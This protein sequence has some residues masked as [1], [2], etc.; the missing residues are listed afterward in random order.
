MIAWQE[1]LNTDAAHYG[2]GDVTNPDPVMPEDGR[3][4][5]TLPPLATIWLTPLAL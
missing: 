5:L 1:I 2:G 3:V 4:R